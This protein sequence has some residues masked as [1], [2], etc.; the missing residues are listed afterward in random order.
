MAT[1]ATKNNKAQDVFISRIAE[2]REIVKLL[3][4]HLDEHMG[5]DPEKVNWADAGDAGRLVELLREAARGCNL[6][7]E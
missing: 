5:V 6:I 1:T 3:S 2:A 7:E 4:A